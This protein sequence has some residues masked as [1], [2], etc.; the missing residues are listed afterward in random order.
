MVGVT[1]SPHLYESNC[2]INEDS[3]VLFT[4]NEKIYETIME[5]RSEYNETYKYLITDF[6]IYCIGGKCIYEK[7]IPLCDTIWVTNLKQ[8][9]ECDLF[10]D[11]D[12]SKDYDMELYEE[13]EELSIIRYKVSNKK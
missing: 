10:F 6:K 2:R 8:E 4:S 3:N 5:N 12:Y 11:Y 7:Y 1:K 9:Y 13:T